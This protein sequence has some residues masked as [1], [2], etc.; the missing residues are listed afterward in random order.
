M[1]IL[2]RIREA[3]LCKEMT[4][5][6]FIASIFCSLGGL[7]FGADYG[8]WS[9]MLGMAE[10]KKQFGVYDETTDSYTIPSV[11][12]SVGSAPPTAGL[13]IGAL[14]SGFLGSKYG[15]LNTFRGSSVVS[16][17]GI[18]I[19]STAISSYWQIVAGRIVNALA[20]GVLANTV[21]AYLAEVAPLSIRGT[22]INC[23][24]F[25]IGVGAVLINTCNWG[26]HERTD[27]W[28]YRLTIILQFIIPIVY[29]P[30]SFFIPESPRWL[31][32]KGRSAEALDSLMIL[33]SN[34]P[35]DMIEQEMK[36]KSRFSG[37]WIECFRGTNL[38]RTL[39]ATGM[40][41]LQQAQGS[42]FMS[43]YAVVF[44][45]AIGVQNEYQIIVLLLFVQTIASAFAFY[46]PDRFGRRWI[47][48]INAL[49]MAICMYVVSLV[50]GYSFANNQAGT[51]G[52][53]AAL[54]IWQFSAAVGWSSCVWIVTAEV[55]T[56]QLREKTI[57][58]ATFAGFCVS[59]LVTFVNPFMQDEGYGNLQGR[60]GFVYGS[61]SIA[62]ALWTFFVYP[63]TGFRSLEELDEMF[64]KG[65]SVW[66]FRSYQTSGFGAQL[67]EVEHGVT[68]G[69]VAASNA[70]LAYLDTAKQ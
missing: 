21:P 36:N 23:Y 26:M 53:I 59:I 57:T 19:Q 2:A 40:Q 30:G 54:F 28:A 65:V 9:G 56:L 39:I 18:L 64:Y 8:F 31:L 32:G 10:F 4:W 24:Q 63:E 7:G 1:G 27:Q 42:S 52:A 17:I 46:L 69:Q 11:W 47:L 35:R 14:I 66:N 20:L 44:F 12:Q 70:K 62:A 51:N 49:V 16:V 3:D 13:A 5:R 48:I 45:Q 38:R 33:R 67:A 41:C 34:M 60:V 55:P 37:N 15:R 61:F 50:K 6:L 43:S 58:V 22:L 68:H 25:S 29:I